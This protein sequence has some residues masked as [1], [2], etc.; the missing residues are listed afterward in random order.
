MTDVKR[1]GRPTYLYD[2]ILA[3]GR[4]LF[5]SL[6][7]LKIQEFYLLIQS[8]QV[9]NISL[10]S[11][12]QYLRNNYF[13]DR[14]ETFEFNIKVPLLHL[15]GLRF[16]ASCSSLI[17]AASS[18][19]VIALSNLSSDADIDFNMRANC[20]FFSSR[21]LMIQDFSFLCATY[22]PR[23]KPKCAWAREGRS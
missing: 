9:V 17:P 10:L 12:K 3:D 23:L 13:G 6:I 15:L 19:A 8:V 1:N 5:S 22:H 7:K 2:R 11:F 4:P 20:F 21:L 14:G 16:N 18:R